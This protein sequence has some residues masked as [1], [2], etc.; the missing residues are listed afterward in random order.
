MIGG[1][2]THPGSS[3]EL[4]ALLDK[5]EEMK[6]AVIRSIVIMGFV[7]TVMTVALVWVTSWMFP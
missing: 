3:P 2:D 1:L 4:A 7:N 6:I 5:V